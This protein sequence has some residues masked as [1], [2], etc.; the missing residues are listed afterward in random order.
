MA[1]HIDSRPPRKQYARQ[2]G[3]ISGRVRRIS[4]KPRRYSKA[5][6]SSPAVAQKGK[7]QELQAA[8]DTPSDMSPTIVRLWPKSQ[9]PQVGGPGLAF[10]T[11]ATHSFASPCNLCAGFALWLR[12][13]FVYCAP[14]WAGSSS[15]VLMYCCEA[16]RAG[17]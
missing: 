7:D 1:I 11:W 8:C 3:K 10:E 16:S 9:E 4:R 13:G 2:G 6:A 12:R 14:G 5:V 17:R 15:P